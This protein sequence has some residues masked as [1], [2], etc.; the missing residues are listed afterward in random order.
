MY[1]TELVHFDGPWHTVEEL[2][3]ATLLWVDWYNTTRLHSSIG[4]QTPVAYEQAHWDN[5]ITTQMGKQ[6]A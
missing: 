3:L 6:T 4:Y 2:E 1:K 5:N